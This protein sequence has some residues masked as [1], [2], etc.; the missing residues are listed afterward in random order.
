MTIVL[1]LK[2]DVFAFRDDF[3]L[4]HVLIQ[5]AERSQMLHCR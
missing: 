2:C 5:N 1:Y 3:C 4:I